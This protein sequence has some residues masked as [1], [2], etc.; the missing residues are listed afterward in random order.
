MC[1]CNMLLSSLCHAE[2]LKSDWLEGWIGG[3]GAAAS[4]KLLSHLVDVTFIWT[5]AAHVQFSPGFY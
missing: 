2:L 5:N 1:I 3:Q 4:L